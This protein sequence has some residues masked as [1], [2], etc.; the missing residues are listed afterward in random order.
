MAGGH[1]AVGGVWQGTQWDRRGVV[2]GYSVVGEVWQGAIVGLGCGRGV[3][4]VL[5]GCH[6]GH[7]GVGGAWQGAMV[8]LEGYGMGT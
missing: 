1:N 8:G 2:G 7:N 6:R 3:I 4:M 5:E